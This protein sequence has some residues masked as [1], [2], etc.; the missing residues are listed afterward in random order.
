MAPVQAVQRALGAFARELTR[1]QLDLSADLP[2]EQMKPAICT[3]STQ[4]RG[5]FFRQAVD[6]PL[7]AGAGG[8]SCVGMGERAEG[9]R[10]APRP[11]TLQESSGRA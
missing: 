10:P 5:A 11:R 1:G 7:R 3:V 6:C 2:A 8:G 9:L 4:V